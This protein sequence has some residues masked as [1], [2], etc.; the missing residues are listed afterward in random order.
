MSGVRRRVAISAARLSS[1]VSRALGRG[2]G[3]ALPGLVAERL[4]PDLVREVIAQAALGTVL[5]SGTNGKTTTSLIVSEMVRAAGYDPLHNHAGSNLMRGIAATV[6]AESSLGG[7]LDSAERRLAVLELDEAALPA[8][9][10]AIAPRAIVLLNLFRDQL[11]RY[12]EVDIVA[13]K[14]RAMVRSLPPT[15]ILVLN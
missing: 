13:D 5:V 1:V 11:D 15:T 6:V 9:A 7:R 2:G 3:T 4:D 10:E 12:G 8:A 14:W